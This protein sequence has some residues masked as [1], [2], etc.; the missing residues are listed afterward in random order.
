MPAQFSE[1]LIGIG[2]GV[3][4]H[5]DEHAYVFVS[6]CVYTVFLK[7]KS[8]EESEPFSTEES[9]LRKHGFSRL[10]SRKLI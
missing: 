5:R 8:T 7:K 1:V 9:E 4:I 6:V 2:L 10:F 3:C